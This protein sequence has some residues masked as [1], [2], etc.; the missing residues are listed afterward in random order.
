[1]LHVRG[2]RSDTS[3]DLERYLDKPIDELFPE[4]TLPVVTRQAPGLLDDPRM[5]AL[6]WRSGHEPLSETYRARHEGDYHRT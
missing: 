4:P 6:S 2:T 1:M 5:E 3:H